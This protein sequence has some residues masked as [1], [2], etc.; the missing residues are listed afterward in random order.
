MLAEWV[1][2]LLVVVALKLAASTALGMSAGSWIYGLFEGFCGFPWGLVLNAALLAAVSGLAVWPL[3]NASFAAAVKIKE[4]LRPSQGFQ[5]TSN[6]IGGKIRELVASGSINPALAAAAPAIRAI[7]LAAMYVMFAW[8]ENSPSS[9][10][11]HPGNF[12]IVDASKP[13]TVSVVLGFIPLNPAALLA[14]AAFLGKSA[15][16]ARRGL[17]QQTSMQVSMAIVFFA[18]NYNFASGFFVYWL[19][20]NAVLVLQ[21]LCSPAPGILHEK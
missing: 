9:A 18:F 10:I 6:Q 19:V 4:L 8:L 5:G 13:D 17:S 16:S 1:L 3:E 2:S 7:L 14:M 20:Q 11:S 15:L 12:W 21:M